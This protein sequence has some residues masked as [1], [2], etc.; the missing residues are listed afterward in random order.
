MKGISC[1]CISGG[2]AA[3]C[4]PPHMPCTE[5]PTCCSESGGRCCTGRAHAPR[6]TGGRAP[7]SRYIAVITPVVAPT[8]RV[9]LERSRIAIR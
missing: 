6:V 5:M 1:Q 4:T 7:M 3:S 2:D 8:A 9:N